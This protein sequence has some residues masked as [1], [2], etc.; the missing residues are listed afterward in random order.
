MSPD[1][2]VFTISE[3]TSV[4]KQT[5]EDDLRNI[6]VEGEI[7]NFR[8]MASGHAY[9]TLKDGRAQLSAVIFAGAGIPSHALADGRNI[10]AFGEISVYE[11][12]GQ[13][14]L[15][16]RKC[17]A[18][19]AGVNMLQFEAL[20]KRLLD[21]GLFDAAR[22]RPLPAFPR[23]VGVVTSPTGAAI[24]DILNILGR[25]FATLRVTLAPARVQGDGAAADLTKALRLLATRPPGDRPDVIIIGRGGGS[26]EDLWCFND[27]ALARAVAASPV[28]V[29]SCVGHETDFTIC[30]FAADLRAP[31]PSAAAEL[32]VGRR[33]D[34][35]DRLLA[36]S[37]R[38]AS[39]LGGARDRASGRLS[40]LLARR[41]LREP[42]RL[43][44]PF[45]Q[46]L[47]QC[48]LRLARAAE[49]FPGRLRPRVEALA[50]R[51]HAPLRAAALRERGR[52]AAMER[53]LN[54]LNPLAVLGRGYSLTTL[55]DGAVVRDPGQAPP[56]ARLH[57]RVAHGEIHSRVEYDKIT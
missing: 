27:E 55:D 30:D 52:L 21:E 35:E 5:L 1:T 37:R 34:F 24:E 13:Y 23:H 51:L 19:G 49:N 38:L 40:A 29:V 28:P 6:W 50:A 45:A 44:E 7:S 32:V 20:K 31:T 4:I 26:L 42:A 12:R 15:I 8:R 3:L 17:E 14:Q 33:A 25:R 53:Q 11:P 56:G 41:A 22:K 2:R 39:A 18:A 9:F 36:F 47:D 10:R 46:R 54:T 48:R 57:T 16:I 43:A